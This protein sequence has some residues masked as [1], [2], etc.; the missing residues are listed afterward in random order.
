MADGK[1]TIDTR[2]NNAGFKAGSRELLTA[3]KSLERTAAATGKS[4]QSS[5]A[6]YGSAMRTSIR[7]TREFNAELKQLER[8]TAQMRKNLEYRGTA[9]GAKQFMEIT[10]KIRKYEKALQA[11]QERSQAMSDKMGEKALNSKAFWESEKEIE[12][13]QHRLENLHKQRDALGV[14]DSDVLDFS[15]QSR[16]LA[17]MEDRLRELRGV[18]EDAGNGFQIL[19]RNASGA[20]GSIVRIVGHGVL[21]FLGKLATGAKNAAIQLAKLASRAA[22]TGL[23]NIGQLAGG[24]TKKLLGLGKASRNNSLGFQLN[25]KTLLRY[26][27]G[28]RSTFVLFNRLRRAIKEGFTTLSQYDPRVKASLAS[29]KG[30][31]GG[32]KGSLSAAFAPIL[33]AVAPALTTL[34]NMLTQAINALGMFFAVLTGQGYYTAAKGLD[35]VSSAAQGASGSA[36]DLKRQLAGFDELNILTANSGGGGGGGAGYS[37]EK[38]PIGGAIAE[39]AEQI[40]ALIE[41]EDWDGL[42]HLLADKINGAIDLARKFISWDN[43]GTKIKKVVDG[44]TGTFNGLVDGINWKN[45]GDTFATGLNTILYTVDRFFM[46]INWAN[47]GKAIGDALNGAISGIDWAMLGR[48]VRERAG[49]LITI[50]K[51]ALTTIEW[52][53]AGTNLAKALNS[54]FSDPTI[55]RDAG[56]AVNA[57]LKGILNFTEKFNITFDPAQAARDINEFLGRIKWAEIADQ[58]WTNAKLAFGNLNTFLEELFGGGGK[59]VEVIKPGDTHAL[60]KAMLAADKAAGSMSKGSDSMASTLSRLSITILNA[61][62]KAFNDIPWDEWGQKIHDF[63]VDIDWSGVA[64]ALWDAIVAAA[65]GVGKLIISALFGSDSGLFK[66]LFPDGGEPTGSKTGTKSTGK[67]TDGSGFGKLLGL[68]AGV[69]VGKTALKSLGKILGIGGSAGASATGAGSLA[70]VSKFL[71]VLGVTGFAGYS[72]GNKVGEDLFG[73][74]GKFRK[75]LEAITDMLGQRIQKYAETLD[76]DDKQGLISLMADTVAKEVDEVIGSGKTYDSPNALAALILGGTDLLEKEE[77]RYQQTTKQGQKTL[78]QQPGAMSGGHKVTTEELLATGVLLKD[79]GY[80]FEEIQKALNLNT[81]QLKE[82]E[83]QT[84]GVGLFGKLGDWLTGT[85]RDQTGTT[86]YLRAKWAAEG[87]DLK[88]WS[89]VFGDTVDEVVKIIKDPGNRTW[90]TLNGGDYEGWEEALNGNTKALNKNTKV[91]VKATRQPEIYTQR[92]LFHSKHEKLMYETGAGAAGTTISKMEGQ[93]VDI[94]LNFQPL[95]VG[96]ASYINKPLAWLQKM[97]APGTDEKTR[98]ELVKKV[99]NQTPATLFETG[100]VLG[101]FASLFKKDSKENSGWLFGTAFSTFASLFKKNNGENSGSLFGT[102]ISVLATLGKKNSKDSSGGLFGTLIGVLATLGKKNSKD[103]PATLYGTALGVLSTLTKKPGSKDSDDLYKKNIEVTATIKKAKNNTIS[104][105]VSQSKAAG[106]KIV[107]MAQAMGGIITS[108]GRSLR[109]ANGGYLTGGGRAGWWDSVSKYAAGSSRAHGTLFVAGEAGPEIVGHVGGRTE[110]LNRSQLAQTMYSAVTAGM[111]AALR[112]VTFTIPNM[113]TGSIMPYEV[114]A[115]VAKSMN[116]L[117]STM[118]ANNE[119]LIQ[120]IISV[121]GQIVTAIQ[122]GNRSQPTGGNGITAQDVIDEI[123]R[124]TL[125]FGA[126]PLKGV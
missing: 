70:G 113:A 124:Q 21:S 89:D 97:F 24:A 56:D 17:E 50:L 87:G 96:G 52:G 77:Q 26:G 30:A 98:I 81:E 55:W 47:I 40:K 121:A 105:T 94:G 16:T 22:R 103:S 119:D 104:W 39:F 48:V 35:A 29:L 111:V 101:V 64:D 61:I 65:T 95:G 83:H 58:F 100:K 49:S 53:N 37:F 57:A 72:F 86:D 66:L 19:M 36:K 44:I 5:A 117:Q 11:A 20:A 88:G 14:S 1:I 59:K 109:F 13:L 4:M 18:S 80:S 67:T 75:D 31:L 33:T 76:P 46:G 110:V 115:Q 23:R 45:I 60:E 99:A 3:I 9:T 108:A 69:T 54:F 73:E 125:M 123:N 84:R 43:L 62:K 68:G 32:L 92:T 91:E 71:G 82:L 122:R 79:K 25:L 41:A 102:L 8:E 90:F 42:G 34:I 15:N 93:T 85:N 78:Q 107:M 2:L 112:G 10:D 51:N 27:L 116:D 114:Y 74:G 6:G 118:D 38:T 126:S 12:R 120:T 106:N 63:L 7:A 28:I